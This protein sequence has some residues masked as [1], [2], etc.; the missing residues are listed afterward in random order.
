[1]IDHLRR[2]GWLPG[3]LCCAGLMLGCGN[4]GDIDEDQQNEVIEDTSPAPPGV[5]ST[6]FGEPPPA[7]TSPP[8]DVN[9]DIPGTAPSTPVPAP[10]DQPSG[11][12]GTFTPEATGTPGAPLG[13][14]DSSD[15]TVTDPGAGATEAEAGDQPEQASQET[16]QP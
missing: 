9:P 15:V 8:A 6:D 13:D 7:T 1:M 16:A 10:P 12:G 2:W 4:Q 11:A 14:V 3:L 5:P